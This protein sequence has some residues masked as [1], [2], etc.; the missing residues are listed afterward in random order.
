MAMISVFI[1][2]QEKCVSADLTFENGLLF[3]WNSFEK[4]LVH[5]RGR[6]LSY[7]ARPLGFKH[8]DPNPFIRR[9]L[10]FMEKKLKDHL[11][12]RSTDRSTGISDL[13]IEP[14]PF[15]PLIA[16]GPRNFAIHSAANPQAIE[17][18]LSTFFQGIGASF[19]DG[20]FL[21]VYQRFEKD[22]NPLV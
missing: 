10:G 15:S 14:G 21:R 6:T 5:V 8:L 20:E 18:F 19:V 2:K 16:G 11:P 7:F 22:S 12:D 4:T 13:H 1:E 17:R 9:A 3:E